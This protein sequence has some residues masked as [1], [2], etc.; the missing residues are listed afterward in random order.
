VSGLVDIRA[1]VIPG[2]DDGPKGHEADPYDGRSGRRSESAFWPLFDMSEAI[3]RPST[4]EMSR[5]G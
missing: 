1:H 5:A 2:I 4:C 3:F